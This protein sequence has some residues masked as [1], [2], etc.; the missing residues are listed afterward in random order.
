MDGQTL[1]FLTVQSDSNGELRFTAADGEPLSVVGDNIC[2]AADSHHGSLSAPLQL[3]TG[4]NRPYK[5]IENDRVIIIR[6]GERYD[7]TGL[8]IQLLIINY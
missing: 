6:D 5:V 7:M 8:K 2:Y 4:N 1:F 3:V